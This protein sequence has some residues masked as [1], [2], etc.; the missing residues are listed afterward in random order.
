ME[1]TARRSK[2]R[3]LGATKYV[4]VVRAIGTKKFRVVE[5]I[6]VDAVLWNGTNQS[7]PLATVSRPSATRPKR[8]PRVQTTRTNVA[9][10]PVK[11]P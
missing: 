6:G 5:P 10:H 3:R 7:A 4:G 11:L 2:M 8:D 1:N 9:V